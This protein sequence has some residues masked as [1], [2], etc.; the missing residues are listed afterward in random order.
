[1]AAASNGLRIFLIMRKGWGKIFAMEGGK[2]GKKG[3]KRGGKAPAP[4]L[5][6]KPLISNPRRNARATGCIL[7]PETGG[8]KLVQVHVIFF[9]FFLFLVFFF[10]SFFFY[11]FLLFCF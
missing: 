4:I 7:R 10:C 9:H 3:G 11:T 8:F 1:M 6:G 5:P 2:R